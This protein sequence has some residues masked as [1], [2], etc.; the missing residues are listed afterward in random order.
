MLCVAVD[1]R[2]S[3]ERLNEFKNEIKVVNP[4]A[5]ILLVAT[6]YDCRDGCENAISKQEFEK[7]RLDHGF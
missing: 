7:V 1:F 2:D 4:N 5:P 6:K 3:L